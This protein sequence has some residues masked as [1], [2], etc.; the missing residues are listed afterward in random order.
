MI[1]SSTFPTEIYEGILEQI[2]PFYTM[3]PLVESSI[4][5]RD[6][7]LAT[8]C[9]CALTCRAW[10][11]TSRT[12]LYRNLTFTTADK[13]S[14]E[15]FVRSLE[16]NPWL[17]TLIKALDIIDIDEDFTPALVRQ[18]LEHEMDISQTWALML[19]GKLPRLHTLGVAFA[20]HLTRP[21][22][23]VKSLQTFSA[24]T[25]LSLAW[26]ASGTFTDLFRFIA[27]FHNLRRV[28]VYGAQWAPKGPRNIICP[29]RF[30]MLSV[31]SIVSDGCTEGTVWRDVAYALLQAVAASIG[32]LFIED[33]NIPYDSLGGQPSRTM[34]S[35]H[36]LHVQAV[37]NVD[38]EHPDYERL[39]AWT[40]ALS[41]PSLKHLVLY[42]SAFSG[43]HTLSDIRKFLGHLEKLDVALRSSSLRLLPKITLL[44]SQEFADGVNYP[45]IVADITKYMREV[46]H[47]CKATEIKVIWGI[48]TITGG[49]V[50]RYLTQI[51]DGEIQSFH[52]PP[53]ELAHSPLSWD[54]HSS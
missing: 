9:S 48:L 25:T 33:A 12:C 1:P 53:P 10:L 38:W 39:V 32:I 18:P 40:S 29:R 41:A 6:T 28:M 13:T 43:A 20:N 22:Q 50:Y 27:S 16:E 35:L 11:P 44:V 37:R 8:L 17:K 26:K 5:E 2:G 21:S 31:L 47:S 49:L 7:K 19:A 46:F 51:E 15:H 4:F 34:P 45:A 36:T 3:I 23:F 30:P 52:Q 54:G 42:Y 24:V 14:F